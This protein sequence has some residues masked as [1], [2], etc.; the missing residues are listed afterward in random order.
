MIYRRM[1]GPNSCATC[2]KKLPRSKPVSLVVTEA[3]GY[4]ALCSR[5]AGD[6]GR[7]GL[8]EQFFPSCPDSWHDLWDHPDEFHQFPDEDM[9]TGYI[10]G[11][12]HA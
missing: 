3:L 8:H 9:A 6:T 11:R 7:L 12:S 10:Y 4:R 2:G 1:L 5:C